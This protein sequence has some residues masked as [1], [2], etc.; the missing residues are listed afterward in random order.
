MKG[1]LRSIGILVVAIALCGLAGFVVRRVSLKPAPSAF[2]TE[3][4]DFA[5][6]RARDIDWRGPDLGHKLDLSHLEDRS[7]KTLASV[8]GK[9]P[10]MLVAVN[11]DCGCVP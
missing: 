9:G 6:L 1:R 10:A 7:G 2:L 4:F 8:I 5:L 3:G 11:S